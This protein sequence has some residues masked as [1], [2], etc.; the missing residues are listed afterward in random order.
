M[1][2]TSAINVPSSLRNQIWSLGGQRRAALQRLGKPVEAVADRLVRDVL[3]RVRDRRRVEHAGIALGDIAIDLAGLGLARRAEER[4]ELRT[5]DDVLRALDAPHQPWKFLVLR[6]HQRDVA[7]PCGRS[8]GCERPTGRRALE[9]H[10]LVVIRHR[11]GRGENGPAAHRMAFEA[12]VGLVDEIEAAQVGERI[13]AAES[14]GERR[15][16]A[17]AVARLIERQHDVSAAREL[18]GKSRLRLARIDVAVHGEDAGR[19]LLAWWRSAACRAG[20]SW[21]CPSRP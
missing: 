6:E 17:V 9:H 18:D 15:R 20:R 5:G 10:R 4:Q 7:R 8:F 16:I 13:G 11:G 3:G 14:V 21:C 19:R 12:D 1:K 2:P